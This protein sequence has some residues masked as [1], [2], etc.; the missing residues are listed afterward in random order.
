[1]TAVA[2]AIAAPYRIGEHHAFYAAGREFLY[3]VPSGAIFGLEGLSKTIVDLLRHEALP[4]EAIR[5]RLAGLHPAAEVEAVIEEL[6]FCDVIIN[7]ESREKFPALPEPEFPIQRI[8]LNTTNQCNLACGYCYE[9][10]D[11]KIAESAGKPKYMS[12]EVAQAAIDTLF[13]EAA[14]RPLLHVTFFGG[15]TL[16]NFPLM[17]WAVEYAN[18]KARESGKQVDYSLTTN[19][20]LLTEEIVDFL[21][22]NRIGVTVSIDGDKEL[23]DRMRVFHSGKGSYDVIAPRIKMLL[24]RHKTNSIG[25]RVTLS[26]GVRDVR[27]IYDHLTK[28]LGFQ[29]V[30]FSPA[31]ANP[32]RLYHIGGQ[33]MDDVFDAFSEL[34][35][36]YRDFALK[37][38]QHYFT[39]VN[40]SIKE[41]HQGISKAYT[42]GAGLGLLGVSTSGGIAACHRFA[43]SPVAQM[44]NVLDG[45]VDHGAR[46]Q[47]LE[48]HHIGARPDCHSCWVRPVCAG[49]CYHESFI[50]HGQT[51]ASTLNQCDR[52]RNWI[53]LCLRIYGEIAVHNPQFLQRFDEN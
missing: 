11:D 21:A 10:S 44:G 42:C 19:A 45:G 43:D 23:H 29:G 20:T 24:A 1:M 40:D 47:F 12:T 48:N 15:E 7:G 25:A 53:D 31:T 50:H 34:A 18:K 49:G 46:R 27:R 33:K 38:G 13:K 30:G 6:E 4:R 37:G 2:E 28:E 41:L 3:L 5:S 8:V 52:V 14:G 39:N 9:Y 17:K 35:W 26:S 51:A 36:E 16:L 22:A 32:D